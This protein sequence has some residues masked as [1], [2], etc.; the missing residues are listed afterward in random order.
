MSKKNLKLK[1]AMVESNYTQIKLAKEINICTPCFSKKINGKR[2]FTE[3]EMIAI[4]KALKKEPTDI[5]F[6]ELLPN[7]QQEQF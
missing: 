5:F 1:S 3:S 6:K 4:C 2:D 7:G